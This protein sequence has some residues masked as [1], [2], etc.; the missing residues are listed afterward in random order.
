MTICRQAARRSCRKSCEFSSSKMIRSCPPDWRECS[1][2]AAMR[3]TARAPALQAD[4]S[5]R[6]TPYELVVLD[7]GLPDVDGFEILRRV[8]A[9]PIARQRAR[10][11][12]ARRDRRP[13]AWAR[14]GADDYMTKPFAVAEFEARVRALLRAHFGAGGA[15]ACCAGCRSTP[16]PSA[17]RSTTFR[18]T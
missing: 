13:R 4:N 18:S 6:S 16:K 11:D 15:A 9:P 14:P 10:A 12:R 17:S 3:S 5:L 2:G 7:V 8:E 1:I